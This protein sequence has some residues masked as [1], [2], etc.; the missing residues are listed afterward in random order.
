MR[1]GARPVDSRAMGIVMSVATLGE[2]RFGA[3]KSQSRDR[4]TAKVQE[5]A[6]LIPVSPLPE[7]FAEHHGRIRAE[8]RRVAQPIANNDLCIAAHARAGGLV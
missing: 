4:A 7:A 6:S 3:E 5:R 8:L 2:L 1:P